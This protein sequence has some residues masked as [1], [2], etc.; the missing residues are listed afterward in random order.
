M[1]VWDCFFVPLSWQDEKIS[2]SISLP[3]T[4]FNILL[5]LLKQS[6]LWTLVSYLDPSAGKKKK[7]GNARR[8]ALV[9]ESSKFYCVSM[10]V[11]KIRSRAPQWK[12][13][14]SCF[15]RADFRALSKVSN[16]PQMSHFGHYVNFNLFL[17][18]VRSWYHVTV[19]AWAQMYGPVRCEIEVWWFSVRYLPVEYIIY[20]LLLCERKKKQI[21][22]KSTFIW[23]DLTTKAN[24][25]MTSFDCWSA[26]NH[27]WYQL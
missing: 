22:T 14:C 10:R 9:W 8:Q 6:V 15:D 5:V 27:C 2:F 21:G 26:Y 24:Y 23:I 18:F 7:N 11:T 12:R 25:W 20:V 13:F 1:R 17:T 19:W 4:K 16:Q 3:C